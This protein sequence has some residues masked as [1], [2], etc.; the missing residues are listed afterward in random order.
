MKI[1][2]P[3]ILTVK[4]NFAIF[5]FVAFNVYDVIERHTEIDGVYLVY[6]KSRDQ[7]IHRYQIQHHRTLI[8]TR[9]RTKEKLN[10]INLSSSQK[11]Q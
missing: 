1:G 6:M 2:P 11:S 10:T 5:K 7:D 9:T 4:N 3:K 8:N